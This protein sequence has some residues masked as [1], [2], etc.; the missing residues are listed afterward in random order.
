MIFSISLR[1]ELSYTAGAVFLVMLTI[2]LT[3]LMIRILGQAA[4]GRVNPTDVAVLIGLGA[5]GYLALLLAISVFVAILIVLTRWY[6]DAEMVVWFSSGLG[7]NN[8]VGPI[9]RF[10]TP[11]ILVIAALALFAWPWANQQSALLAQRFSTRDDLSLVTAGQFR[12]SSQ[13]Q[14]VFFIESLN[15]ERNRVGNVFI[16]DTHNGKLGIVVS[17]EGGLH[18]NT[19][20]DHFVT[21]EKGRRYEGVPGNLDFRIIEFERYRA[22]IASK[23]AQHA[24]AT[25]L[26][27]NE[28]TLTLI[29]QPTPANLGELLWRIGL[30]LLA[31]TLTLLAIP[32]A[33]VNPRRGRYHSLAAAVLIYLVY[34]DLLNLFQAWVT[35]SKLTFAMAWW[36]LHLCVLLLALL[37]F[38]IRRTNLSWGHHLLRAILDKR[39]SLKK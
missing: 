30:P 25:S 23:A 3:S 29:K 31:L 26:P 37:F 13:A 24:P 36:P 22:K 11:L 7:L 4:G 12:E 28:D 35:Q 21:L 14:R 33:Y 17:Q 27:R 39:A 18:K 6:R 10:A 8:F 9:L 32:L 15:K 2:M 34:S 5:L 19:E 1:R 16:T 20:G 38:W